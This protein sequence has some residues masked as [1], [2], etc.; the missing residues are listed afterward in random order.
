[1]NFRKIE[2]LTDK[3]LL[4]RDGS[5]FADHPHLDRIGNMIRY[6]R[7]NDV[8]N[9][10]NEWPVNLILIGVKTRNLNGNLQFKIANVGC[11]ETDMFESIT[12]EKLISIFDENVDGSF[13]I[14]CVL[15]TTEKAETSEERKLLINNFLSSQKENL[16]K[17]VQYLF[18]NR[19]YISRT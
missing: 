13:D 12:D 9:P 18:T 3:E 14:I 17:T 11:M 16:N 5:V 10:P 1:M 2:D 6:M 4:E 15:P 19:F 7:Q 8:Y